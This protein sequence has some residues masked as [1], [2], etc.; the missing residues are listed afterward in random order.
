MYV[1]VCMYRRGIYICMLEC[2]CMCHSPAGVCV[3]THVKCPR[4]ALEACMRI[5]LPEGADR[6]TWAKVAM[7]RGAR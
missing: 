4:C 3:H 7:Q 1:Q 6:V 5:G 2:A